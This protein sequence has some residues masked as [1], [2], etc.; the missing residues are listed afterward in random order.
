M[1]PVLE[2][3]LTTLSGEQTTRFPL[4]QQLTIIGRLPDSDI[5]ITNM[6]ISRQHATIERR[7]GHD[8]IHDH[9]TI[10]G[11]VSA[12]RRSWVARRAEPPVMIL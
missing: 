2:L 11:T 4:S 3:T 8:F 5:H 10:W 7:H 1:V 6:W 12:V 9:S